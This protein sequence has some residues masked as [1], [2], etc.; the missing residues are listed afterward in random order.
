MSFFIVIVLRM[1]DFYNDVVSVLNQYLIRGIF[2][3]VLVVWIATLFKKIDAHNAKSILKWTMIGYACLVMV[4]YLLLFAESWFGGVEFS[5]FG[6]EE[7]DSI[8]YWLFFW[9]MMIANTLLPFILLLKKNG[10][11]IILLLFV[12]ISMNF[13][14][15]FE[16]FVIVVTNVHRDYIPAGWGSVHSIHFFPN[17]NVMYL[18]RGLILGIV[19]VGVGNVMRRFQE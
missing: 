13:G 5:G 11:Q 7:S 9:F 17:D 18:L 2:I 14:W 19:V 15:L 16:W 6:F 4:N 12:A 10:N 1:L 8:G 3:S